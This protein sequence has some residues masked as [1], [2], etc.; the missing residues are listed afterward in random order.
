MVTVESIVD[1]DACHSLT[2]HNLLASDPSEDG[3]LVATLPERPKDQ[4]YND[5]IMQL[6]HKEIGIDKRHREYP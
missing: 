5:Y 2:S 4:A 1:S 6:S 3:L